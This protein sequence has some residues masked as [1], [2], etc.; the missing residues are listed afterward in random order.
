MLLEFSRREF[1]ALAVQAATLPAPNTYTYKT[2][3]DCEIK[4]DVHGADGKTGKP[5]LVWVHGGALIMGHRRG[6]PAE[7]VTPLVDA[8]FTVV[9][10]DYRLAP[11]TKLPAIIEDLKDAC[12]WVR[13]KVRLCSA[14]T[15]RG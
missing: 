8:G 11:E 14:W 15:A 1:M 7:F 10:I 4:A 12:G 6:A 2:A 5:V 9:S 3:G 13:G